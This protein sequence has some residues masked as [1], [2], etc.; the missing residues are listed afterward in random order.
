MTLSMYL[1]RP[2]RLPQFAPSCI[3]GLVCAEAILHSE[4]EDGH[5]A[6]L[7]AKKGARSDHASLWWG[8]SPTVGVQKRNDIQQVERVSIEYVQ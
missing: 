6:G 3:D 2:H 4:H 1:E 7:Q 5:G 8:L